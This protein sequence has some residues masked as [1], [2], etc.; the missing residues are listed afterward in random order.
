MPIVLQPPIRRLSQAEFGDLAFGVMR[1]VFEIHQ[2]MGRFFDE[3]IY[4]RELATRHPDVQ[5]EVPIEIRHADFTKTQF[6][7]VV[8]AGAGVFEFKAVEAFTPRHRAQLLH[9]LLLAE[10][11]HGKLVNVRPESVEQEF[12]NTT[13]GHADRICFEVNKGAW[14]DRVAGAATFSET[15]TAILRDWGAGLELQLYEEALTHFLGGEMKVLADVEVQ[16]PDH[17]LGHQK[18]RLAAPRVAFKLTALNETQDA[19]RVMPADWCGIQSWM[20]FCGQ[21]SGSKRSRSRPS[22]KGKSDRK[23]E[24]RKMGKR[25]VIPKRKQIC[26]DCLHAVVRPFGVPLIFLSPI[27]L[28]ASLES[29]LLLR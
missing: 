16:M 13:L 11:A 24:D 19:F 12:V 15:L 4:K 28:S 10:V 1:C 3:K 27:F 5:L 6:L 2:E 14:D 9:Y 20:P 18:M 29:P 21:M 17:T 26:E 25:L 22:G 7:D 23:I 8:V